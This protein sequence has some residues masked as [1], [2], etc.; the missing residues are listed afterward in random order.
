MPRLSVVVFLTR[1]EMSFFHCFY[2]DMYVMCAFLLGFKVKMIFKGTDMKNIYA[3]FFCVFIAMSA[4]GG[5]RSGGQNVPADPAALPSS[6]SSPTPVSIQLTSARNSLSA[7]EISQ[8]RDSYSQVISN[9][10]SSSE[11]KA[12]ASFGRALSNILLL[13][14]KDA[15]TEMLSGLGQPRW[16]LS[17]LLGSNG[18]LAD[19]LVNRESWSAFPFYNIQECV[20]SNSKPNCALS[21]T[22][23]SYRSSSFLNSFEA[24]TNNLDPI[25]SDLQIAVADSDISFTIPQALYF[26][27][28]DLTLNRSDMLQMVSTLYFI[29]TSGDIAH[30]YV[31]DIDLSSLVDRDGRARLSA[32]EVVNLLNDQFSL[33]SDNKISEARNNLQQALAYSLQA[34]QEVRGGAGGG[35]L[36][37]SSTNRIFYDELYNLTLSL[38]QSF[39]GPTNLVGTSPL[40]L[41]DLD[42]FFSNP[43]DGAA[44]AIDPFVLEDGKIK[45]VEAYW[46]QM[47]N[48]VCDVNLSGSRFRL[49]S[50]GL[51]DINRPYFELFQ[52]LNGLHSGRFTVNLP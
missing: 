38:Q 47:L 41:A 32:S 50:E 4:C 49:F 28:R 39:D 6:S 26:G 11:E 3:L 21:R 9:S 16:Y 12:Q 7:G 45:G 18:Y 48:T 37:V 2:N 33:R 19:S 20:D 34:I 30:S 44:I 40:I 1:I 10:S 14:E 42:N 43:A 29:K 52:N 8:A 35:V 5:G 22:V 46:Q 36:S 51:R 31:F 23:S 27:N 17:S 13:I 25:L 15:F 24:W